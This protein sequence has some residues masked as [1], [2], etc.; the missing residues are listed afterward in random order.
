MRHLILVILLAFTTPIVQSQGFWDGIDTTNSIDYYDAMDERYALLDTLNYKSNILFNRSPGF[1]KITK[2]NGLNMDSTI[3]FD[4]W[5]GMYWE[6][7]LSHR[8]KNTLEDLQ[9]LYEKITNTYSENYLTTEALTVPI[10]ILLYR[11]HE[12]KPFALDSNLIFIVNDRQFDEV[13]NANVFQENLLLAASPLIVDEYNDSIKFKIDSNFIFTN[14]RDSIQSIE[15]DFGDGS[16]FRSVSIGNTYDIIYQVGGQIDI[17]TRINLIG[18]VVLTVKS[19]FNLDNPRERDFLENFP[20]YTLDFGAISPIDGELIYAKIGIY[21]NCFTPA[22]LRKPVIYVAGFNPAHLNGIR[23]FYKTYN[24]NNLLEKLRAEGHDIVIVT[25]ANGVDFAE[26]CS[27]LL[28]KIIKELNTMKQNFGQN[29]YENVI[30]GVSAGNF[31]ARLALNQME[32]DYINNI[33]QDFHNTKMYVSYEGEHQG[34]NIPLCDQHSLNS[35]MTV[36]PPTAIGLLSTITLALTNY[37]LIGSRIAKQLLAYH[38]TQTGPDFAPSQGNHSYRDDLLNLFS[39][40]PHPYTKVLGFPGLT[41]NIAV[42]NGSSN[43]LHHNFQDGETLLYID[44]ININIFINNPLFPFFRNKVKLNA[45]NMG[46]NNVYNRYLGLYSL[47][48]FQYL[49]LYK[50]SYWTS[51]SKLIDNAPSGW[52]GFHRV[53]STVTRLAF[54]AIVPD[55]Y[56][57]SDECFTPLLSTLDIRNHSGLDF[58]YD[59]AAN[60]LFWVNPITQTTDRGYPHIKHPNDHY[61]FTTFEAIFA[62]GD[63]EKHVR[64]ENP[65]IAKFLFEE[66]APYELKLQNRSIGVMPIT[67]SAKFEA[68]DNIISGENI[69]YT[70]PVGVFETVGNSDVEFKAGFSI[71]LKPGF[72]AGTGSKFLAKIKKY[73]C[74]PVDFNSNFDEDND[75]LRFVAS[76]EENNNPDEFPAANTELNLYPNP[77]SDAL[78]YKMEND[79]G[80][81][82]ISVYDLSGKIMFKIN[83]PKN[84]M[85]ITGLENG[86]YILHFTQENGKSIVKKLS[87]SK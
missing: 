45:S 73:P 72:R 46:I 87:V 29:N 60:D 81:K 79:Y 18:G 31:S 70:T 59:V 78:F 62:N 65:E 26:N 63:N 21:G 25:F 80:I 56:N 14:L 6:I 28:Q 85:D 8:D 68:R 11:Y 67:Y 38:Y 69:T 34:A 51:S 47:I 7:K 41:R 84:F 35:I 32:Y 54:E 3:N 36:P 71:T 57:S 86:F 24:K 37:Q 44:N 13:G 39:S 55:V 77:A 43:N 49:T 42:A 61:D 15:I 2:M 52:F 40:N 19:N 5:L 30:V 76:H 58:N 17:V 74:A 48:G 16:G 50:K 82:E 53:V 64:N 66:I 23:K 10:G 27:V 1:S 75:N 9:N 22:L 4:D 20:D 12:I 83:S 33:S